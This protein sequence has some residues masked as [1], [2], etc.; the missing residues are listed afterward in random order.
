MRKF[1]PNKYKCSVLEAELK[2]HG[3]LKDPKQMQ[4]E[5]FSWGHL[6]VKSPMEMCICFMSKRK[7]PASNSSYCEHARTIICGKNVLSGLLGPSHPCT[8]TWMCDTCPRAAV[9]APG[10]HVVEFQL[11]LQ[12]SVHR[13][14]ELRMTQQPRRSQSSPGAAFGGAW[15]ILVGWEDRGPYELRLGRP[16]A[17]PDRAEP[18]PGSAVLESGSLNSK[19]NQRMRV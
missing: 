1:L 18:G 9:P 16:C 14:P 4:N 7:N 12:P 13:S 6:G 8:L 15:A 19:E 10:P 5:H 17:V 11:P 2:V 3:V